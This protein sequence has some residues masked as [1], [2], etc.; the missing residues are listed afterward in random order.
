MNV[1]FH[2]PL[3][4]NSE[5]KSASGIRP[6]RMLSAF[7]DLGCQVDLV[8]GYSSERRSRIAF[9]KGKIRNGYKYDFVYSE[10]STMPTI[11]ADPHHLPR[12]PFLDWRFFSFSRSAG[13]PVGLFY[14]DIYWLFDRYKKS[15]HPFKV[16]A[17]LAAY[18]YDLWV[19]QRTL[20]KVYLP[21]VEMGSYIPW[22]D[23]DK[24]AALPP[25][26]VLHHDESSAPTRSSQGM[27]RLFYVGGM[28][29]HYK[30][31]ELFKAVSQLPQVEL[32]VCTREDEWMAVR[33]GYYPLTPN[34]NI[35]HE[36]GERMES[37]LRNCDVAVLSV[38]PGEYW[39]FAS[40]VKLY[41]YIGF[42]KPILASDDTLVGSFVLKHN[43]GWT[44]Q[45]SEEA[46]T[47]ALVRMLYNRVEIDYMRNNVVNVARDHTW[48]ARARQ[49]I[50]DLT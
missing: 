13:V 48:Q 22:L 33:D 20:D 12:H 18:R 36:T 34:I 17:A 4:L 31:H 1:V 9:V 16:W 50:E 45:Y 35:V 30:L 27:L 19:Y 32:T 23:R 11:L 43:I 10:S 28:S 6:L 47:E 29:S 3:P 40:P 37:Y 44:V 46:L 24:M 41:E 7:E 49:V 14:R 25:G 26:C 5:A 39:K 42:H 38:Q 15:M 2:H 8:T 21:S